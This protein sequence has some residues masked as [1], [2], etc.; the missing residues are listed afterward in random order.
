MLEF[1]TFAQTLAVLVM[2]S[3]VFELDGLASLMI[4]LGKHALQMHNWKQS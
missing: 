2:F 1:K 3:L 4:V